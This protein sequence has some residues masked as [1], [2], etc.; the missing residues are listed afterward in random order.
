MSARGTHEV[1][2]G[3]RGSLR[4]RATN[5]YLGRIRGP[6]FAV[7][8]AGRSRPSPLVLRAMRPSINRS[9][10]AISPVP[11]G[12]R[13]RPVRES[14]DSG[15]V[16]GEWVSG[17]RPR[18][19]GLRPSP[20]EAIIYYLHGSGYVVCSPRTHRGLVSRLSRLT[21]MP[22]FSL[23]YRLGPE[24]RL[25]S[26]GD[27]AIRGYRWLLDNGHRAD[28]IVVAGDSAGGHLA[29][30][31]LADNH[32]TGRPQ[33]AAMVLFSPLYDPTFELAVENQ[34]GG[35]RDPL[36]EALAAQQILRFYTAGTDADDPRMRVDLT[37]DMDLPPTLLQYG[38]LEVMG[39]DARALH[40]VLSDAGAQVEIQ[41]WPDQGHVFQMFPL[42]T[43][44]AQRALR[45]AARF[46]AAQP[47][48]RPRGEFRTE[49]RTDARVR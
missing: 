42:F 15:S 33:P 47:I 41:R 44:E 24:Y 19:P 22:A 9:L 16:R 10:A 12:T 30:D 45:D 14:F 35:A 5:A 20:D 31:L 4:A 32:R 3:A 8:G 2:T 37:A 40:Q 26:A 7:T 18:T 21:G 6:L 11:S 34:R 27:D 23:D 46:I 36:I 43:P 13:V 29:A 17:T 48:P 38:G 28:R 39:A 25:P 1:H 49:K